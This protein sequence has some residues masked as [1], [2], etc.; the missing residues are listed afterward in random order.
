M[1]SEG[2]VVGSVC[3]SVCLPVT[4]HLTSRMSVCLK[5]DT[6]YLTRNEGQKICGIFSE[7]ALFVRYGVKHERKS[8]YANIYPSSVSVRR[9]TDASDV[10][11]KELTIPV[12]HRSIPMVQIA[13][14][15]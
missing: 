3:L 12:I 6:I 4:L 5:N 13:R 15:S 11:N 9:T 7:T 10:K 2:T 8:Q 1:R 14:G